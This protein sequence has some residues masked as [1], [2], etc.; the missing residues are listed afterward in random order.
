MYALENDSF[1]CVAVLL[2]HGDSEAQLVQKDT[3]M[4]AFPP[5]D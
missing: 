3:H 4:V 5:K 1:E 2:E